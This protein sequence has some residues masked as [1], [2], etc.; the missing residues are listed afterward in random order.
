MRALANQGFP[1]YVSPLSCLNGIDRLDEFIR[2]TITVRKESLRS[3]LDK[4][5]K[6][7]MIF[8]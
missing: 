3:F 5:G 2:P 8:L 1:R 6:R 7:K 4:L